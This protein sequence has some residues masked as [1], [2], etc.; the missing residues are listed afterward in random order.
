VTRDWLDPLLVP[1]ARRLPS[2]A[3]YL[4]HLE[5]AA[6]DAALVRLAAN[7]CTEPPSPLVREALGR[8][9]LDANL[10]PPPVPPLRRALADR[11]GVPPA[12]VLVGAGSTELVDALFRAVVG[13]G[14]EVVLPAP[15]WP[16]YRRRLTA[17]DA[18]IVEVP[19]LA[20]EREWGYDVNGLLAAVTPRTKLLVLCTPNNPTGNA[21]SLDEVRR[22]AEGAPLLLVDAAYADFDEETDLAPIVHESARVVLARTF[23]KAY[24]LAG[25]RVG[26]AVGDAAL[27]DAVDR[28]LLPGGSVSSASLHAALAAL[29][30]EGHRRRLVERVRRERTRLTDGLREHGLRAFDSRGNFVAVEVQDGQELADRLLARGVLVRVLGE[31]LVRITVGRREENDALLAALDAA[32]TSDSEESIV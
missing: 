3:A 19:L 18:R 28:F 24:A 9:A 5:R 12:R 29:E 17:L 2:N 1:A 23:S 20:G 21:L 10:Y 27:L 13:P 32:S 15:S 14:D 7:E 26:Y 22:C 4:A 11:H 30:D 16:V 8:A 6:A 25:L 31:R